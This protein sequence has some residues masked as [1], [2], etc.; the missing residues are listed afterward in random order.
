MLFLLNDE[1]LDLGDPP[2]RIAEARELIRQSEALRMSRR[3]TLDLAKTAYFK[4]TVPGRPPLRLRMLI[5]ALIAV[6]FEADAAL[7]VKPANARVS[8]DVLSRLATTPMTLLAHLYQMQRLG[9]LEPDYV[10]DAV[11]RHAA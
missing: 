6:K 10:N 8:N 1:V 9:P 7:F 2:T 5:S 3:E 11:W 4:A